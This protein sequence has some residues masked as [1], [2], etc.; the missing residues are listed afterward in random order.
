MDSR[1]DPGHA[2][3][4]LRHHAALYADAGAARSRHDV[5]HRDGAGQSR[6]RR[7]GR[8]GGE[9]ARRI[10]APA[11]RH[12]ALRQLALHRRQAERLS[13]LP[14]R[15]SGATP[16]P[17]APA[18]FP[19]PS[20]QAWDSSAMSTMRSMFRCIS[21]TATAA[22][23]TSPEPR[24]GTFSRAASKSSPASTRPSTTGPTISPRSSPMSG[25]SG[26]S[27]CAAP[28]RARSPS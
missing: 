6:L 17:T 5:P 2:Q 16:T 22:T 21:S 26:S 20:S 25:S 10:G 14:R 8:H 13:V 23:S 3:G 28:T 1:R 7:R 12:R 11:D 18:I 19:S 27:K 4:A 15:R 24:S 9:A